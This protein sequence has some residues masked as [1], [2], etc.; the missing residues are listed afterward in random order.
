MARALR[1][2]HRGDWRAAPENSLAAMVEALHNPACDGLEF[3]VRGSR[4]GVPILL[5][6]GTLGRVQGRPERSTDLTAEELAGVG[7]PS[8][9]AILAVAGPDAF[10]DVELKG[11]PLPAVVAV[12]EASRG[13]RLAR[14]VI[15]SFEADTLAWIGEQRPEWQRWLNV[16]DLELATV[17]LASRLGCNGVSVDWRAIDAA[18][19]KRARGAGLEVAAWTLRRRATAQRLERLGVAAL[20]VEAGALDG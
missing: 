9:E 6:D 11:D 4:D 18:G 5:H 14:T 8:L 16:E 3:D 19:M 20:C 15:S 13:P 12:L 10:L 2:A 1:L 17:A 7:I